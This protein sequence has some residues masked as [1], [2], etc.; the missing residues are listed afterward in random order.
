MRHQPISRSIIQRHTGCFVKTPVP[1]EAQEAV[2]LTTYLRV[3]GF[4]FT[5]IAN[6]TGS[7]Q[8]A[9]F[10]G[11]RNKRQ[12]VSKGF[13]DYMV[14]VDNKLIAIELK[15]SKGGKVSPEQKEWL[16]AL[17]KAG[18]DAFVSYGAKDAIEYI[19]SISNRLDV[20]IF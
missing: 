3:R 11:I 6:E 14:I 13:P 8:G 15:R 9:K 1:T 17:S 20:D 16:S 18:V 5:H 12:G 4:R 19:E 10:Q 7:G 2:T